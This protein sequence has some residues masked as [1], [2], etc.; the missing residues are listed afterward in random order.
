MFSH[1]ILSDGLEILVIGTGTLYDGYEVLNLISKFILTRTI[2]LKYEW[3]V[4]NGKIDE[5]NIS[6]DNKRLL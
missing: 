3:Q 2:V 4:H 5:T 6:N 1:N